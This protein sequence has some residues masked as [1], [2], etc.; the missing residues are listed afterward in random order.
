MYFNNACLVPAY[1]R[2]IYK[3]KCSGWQ[4]GGGGTDG[5][6]ERRE[7]DATSVNTQLTLLQRHQGY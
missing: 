2:Q 1:H 6:R 7:E 4:E 5:G 3:P